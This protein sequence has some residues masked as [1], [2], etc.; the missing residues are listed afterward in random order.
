MKLSKESKTVVKARLVDLACGRIDIEK[1]SI[2]PNQQP[3]DSS[4]SCTDPAKPSAFKNPAASESETQRQRRLG[5]SNSHQELTSKKIEPFEEPKT[6]KSAK[7]QAEPPQPVKTTTCEITTCQT[8]ADEPMPV[9]LKAAPAS[10][11]SKALAETEADQASTLPHQ[12][13]LR[14]IIR[15]PK[16]HLLDRKRHRKPRRGAKLLS[17]VVEPTVGNTTTQPNNPRKRTKGPQQKEEQSV[18]Q[19]QEPG[20]GQN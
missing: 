1:K 3:P 15:F 14:V 16:R 20:K 10:N 19:E 2:E 5:Q 13:H 18:G 7:E 8:N 17:S 11:N 9:L 12:K 4:E 6:N